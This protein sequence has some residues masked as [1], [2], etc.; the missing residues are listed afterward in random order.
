M[1]VM[2][3]CRYYHDL[4]LIAPDGTRKKRVDGNIIVNG[5]ATLLE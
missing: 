5:S 4:F 3:A 1:S 2:S